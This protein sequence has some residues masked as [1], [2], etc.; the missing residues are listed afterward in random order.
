MFYPPNL[1]ICALFSPVKLPPFFLTHAPQ[2]HYFEP[3]GQEVL[4]VVYD[5]ENFCESK[6]D[7]FSVINTQ[8]CFALAVM[9]YE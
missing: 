5:Q 9:I 3:Q 2:K 4:N 8:F 6:Y 1:Q 7:H